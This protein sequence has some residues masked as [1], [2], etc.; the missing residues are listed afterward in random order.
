MNFILVTD[1]IIPEN[2]QRRVFPQKE[3]DDLKASI[4]SKGLMHAPVV[5]NDGRTLV[6]GERRLRALVE[7]MTSGGVFVYHGTVVGNGHIPVVCLGELSDLDIV[8]AE[9][10]EN[11]IRLDLSWQERAK[12]IGALHDL[13]LAQATL[14]GK[15]FAMIDLDREVNRV[16]ATTAPT[17]VRDS[18]ILSKHMDIP[19]VAAAKSQ[20]EAVK[21]LRKI[22]ETEHRAKL[23]DAFDMEGTEHIVLNGDLRDLM[24]K[25]PDEMYDLILTD[26]PYGVDADSFGDMAST[27]HNYK[28][29]W[30]Y[31]RELYRTIANEGYRV[32]KAEAHI[33]AFCTFEHF[34][35]IQSE[36]DLAGWNVWPRPIIWSKGNGMLPRPEHGPRYTYE[37]ILYASKGNRKVLSVRP[38]VITLSGDAKLLHGAQKPVELYYELI[39]RSCLP[40]NTILDPT[41][42]SGPVLTAASQARCTATL[43]ERDKDN[44]NICLARLE[45]DA[46]RNDN[47]E[48]DLEL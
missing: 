17:T 18:V 1:I 38:D 6:A 45:E 22:K 12:A 25:D 47:L 3:M 20:K 36:F 9:L 42:G 16:E 2:R 15:P 14:G 37:C 46:L 29:T 31:A 10:E 21:V 11:I 41:G 27:G 13:R 35:E 23:A 33:Y 19:E 30:E 44:F 32:A 26:P 24:P 34:A 39:S 8:E 4:L 40:G 48:I 5:R 43:F 7:I 28:D